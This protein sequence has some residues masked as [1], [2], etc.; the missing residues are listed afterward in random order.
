MDRHQRCNA[1]DRPFPEG[2]PCSVPT[3]VASLAETSS[4]R[5]RHKFSVPPTEIAGNHK[6]DKRPDNESPSTS[7]THS[8]QNVENRDARQTSKDTARV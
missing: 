1:A 6:S 8:S 4:G 7:T 2:E 5:D 3:P